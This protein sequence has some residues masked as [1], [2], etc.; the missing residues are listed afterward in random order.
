MN[1]RKA[2]TVVMGIAISLGALALTISF[3]S[4]SSVKQNSTEITFTNSANNETAQ[5]KAGGSIAEKGNLKL[6]EFELLQLTTDESAIELVS[7]EFN[8][9]SGL[10]DSARVRVNS[11]SVLAVNLMFGPELT[12][13]DD[14]VAVVNQ[15]GSF[16]FEK[17]TSVA[18]NST[19]V[20]ALSG[21]TKLT[22]VNT[23]NS[24]T[25]EGTLVPGEEVDLD[26][27]T[28]ADIFAV[29]DEI[30]RVQ[31]WRGAIG[32][33]SSQFE[34]EGQ[35][36]GRFLAQ[37]PDG[38]TN[39]ILDALKEKL[40]FTNAKRESFYTAQLSGAL[41]VAA[42]S[43]PSQF[44]TLLA[45]ETDPA[46][47]EILKSVT[48]RDL[49]YT[50]L[51]VAKS[52]SPALKEEIAQLGEL[53][54]EIANFTEIAPLSPEEILNRNL[55]FILN[56]SKNTSY[57]AKF[58]AHVKKG[59]EG[60]D[61]ASARLLLAILKIDPQSLTAE[62]IDAWSAV[63]NARAI[64]NH[65]LAN[66]ITDQL[67]LINVLIKAGRKTLSASALKELASLLS[68]GSTIFSPDSLEI[69][70]AAGNELRNRVLFLATLRDEVPF[71]EVDY[72][73]WL[74]NRDLP[75]QPE[76]VT[77]PENSELISPT[78]DPNRIARPESELT[79]FL[80]I[81]FTESETQAAEEKMLEESNTTFLQ[82]CANGAN[83]EA[84]F[85]CY[86]SQYGG[87]GENGLVT[88]EQKGDL[89]CHQ[90]CK[91]DTDCAETWKCREVEILGGDVSTNQKMC[92]AE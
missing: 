72:Q 34:G 45:S 25:F 46:K 77:E 32:K 84:G 47:L 51:F 5:V 2:I 16:I 53:T 38:A 9:K 89:L 91:S 86:N 15:G 60:A 12:L 30:A 66:A 4:N 20:R 82:S 18:K 43:D 76:E 88:G 1:T 69:V 31:T 78:N 75:E 70:A 11:G 36:V 50:R 40:I 64:D 92:F 14:R 35:L 24:E 59:I 67:E 63:N 90:A 27:A 48:A 28:I 17:Q 54:N 39:G 29:G 87:M 26:D 21:S 85:L 83:C 57:S 13:L 41:A 22:L 55:I 74:A 49:F 80:N 33:F 23:A 8:E 81:K 65:D 6:G 62:W 73:A 61:E 42:N 10:L 7:A 52:L 56:D 68:R 79:K 71:N 37:L 3:L 58:L 19:I 44:E